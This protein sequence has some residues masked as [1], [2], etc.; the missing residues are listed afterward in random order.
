LITLAVGSNASNQLLAI[1]FSVESL[2]L[3]TAKLGAGEFLF[4]DKDVI[5]GARES[6]RKNHAVGGHVPCSHS[7]AD[8]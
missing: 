4:V 5:F 6:N 1:P 3:Q 2:N 8:F 7:L